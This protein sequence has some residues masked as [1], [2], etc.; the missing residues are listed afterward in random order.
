T[1]GTAIA[2]TATPS[3]GS[4][5]AGFSG[6]NC[7]GSF[8]ITAD[9]NC[10]ATFDP[11]PPPQA[12]L[13][14]TKADSADPVNTSTNFSYTL[15]V[16]NAGP[17]AASNVRVVDTLPAGVSFV[18]ASGT[19]WTCN[20]TGGTVTCELANLAVGGANL[21]TINVTAP[22]T[23]G[24]IT[25]QATVSATTADLDT[26]NNS[27]SETTMVAPQPLLHTLTVT[28]VGNGTV[29]ANGID[30]DNDCE[31]SYSSGTNVTL[32][33]TPNADSTFAGFSGDAN[34]SDS[35]T[36]TADM[37]CTATFNLQPTPVFQLSLQTDGTGSGVVSSQPAGIDCGTDCT[38]NYQSGTALVLTATPDGGSTFAGFSGDANCSESFTITADMNCTATFNLLPPPPPPTYTLTI[39]TDGI[40]SG[41]VSSDPTGIDCGTDCTENYQSG[42]AVTLTATPATDDSAFLGWMGDCSG[43]ETSLTITMDAAKNCTAHFD[44]TASSY[45]FPTTY[46]IPDCPTKGLV[47]GI[48]NA[49]WQTQNDVTIDTK[50]QVSNVVLK[51]ITTNNG[52]LSNAVIEPNATLCGGI[53]TGYITNQGIMCDFEFRGASVTGGTLSGVINNTREGTFKDLHLKA[54][55]QLSGGKIAGKITG[56]SD[57]PAWLDNLEVQAGSELSGV[58]LGDDVQLPE[59]V[60]LGKGVRF[61][62]KSLIPT[63]LELT[64]LLPTLPEPANCADKVTQPKRVDLSIDV[65]LDSESILGAINDLP[66]FKD[67]GWEVTQDALSGDL[68]LTVDVLHFAV[69]PLSVKH[70]TDEAILQ[71][72][73]TQSTRFITKTERD[74][75]TQP[76]V[77]A[78]CELQT[79][80][81]ELGLPNV[82]VQT[83]GNLKIPASQESWYSARPDFASVEV[84]DETPLG[85]HIVE[86]STVNG[87]SQVKLVFDSN[88]KRREQMFYPAIAVPE[89]LYASARKV[90]IESN[91]M[92]NFKWGGQNYR[93]VL[94]YLI[95]KSTPSNDEMQVQS[96]PDQ[97]GDGIED[98]VL[99]YPT[100]E[101]QILFAVSGDN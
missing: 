68:L 38:E 39:Q 32:T 90:I 19:D 13:L 52:W 93:G 61:T 6:T 17:D 35:F 60:K 65:L 21:I 50:G 58:V 77:Q 92:V 27:V 44:F 22:S 64:E 25:N 62:S 83:N 8:T 69:Q 12:D 75:L 11:L 66:D 16:N 18:S 57:A 63:D 4:T 47:N 53:V 30:C 46:E 89:A 88:G 55:T 28:T 81:E 33:A 70:T 79:A 9:M 7:S 59:E 43:F 71:V 2:L 37:N 3:A 34:C 29:T 82:T 73:D 14:L 20:E 31:E 99:F 67:N 78:P 42:T 85:L 1:S 98:F 48:C 100:G 74:I 5:F 86:Q 36:I 80:L 41:K 76:A 56:E 45:Y 40:G 96:L 23:T 91:V 24:D 101:Q 84:A 10:T 49:Q 15:T 51:G 87:G 94:D 54:N 95:T 97:N 72:Q 26:S